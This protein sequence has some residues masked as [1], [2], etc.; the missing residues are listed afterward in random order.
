MIAAACTRV[1]GASAMTRRILLALF[2]AVVAVSCSSSS[3]LDDDQTPRSR[4]SGTQ[5]ELA[6]GPIPEAV[7]RDASGRELRMSIE[8]P[9]RA[10]SYPLIIFSPGYAAT[11][12]SY[13][14]LTSH[15]ASQGYVV[16]KPFHETAR[17]QEA[18][19]DFWQ[20]QTA[21][22]WRNRVRDITMILDSLDRLQQDYPELQGKIDR[23]KIGVG[24]HSYGAFTAMLAGGVRTYP[25]AVSYADPR[26]TAVMAISPQG[27]GAVRGLTEQSF[28]ELRKPTLFLT[29]TRDMG[30]TEEE[31]PEWRRRAYELSPEGDKWFVVIPNAGQTAFT[32]LRSATGERPALVGPVI[33]DPIEDPRRNPMINPQ[34]R[35]PRESVAGLRERGLGSDIRAITLAFWDTYLRGSAEART[36]LE[37][38]AGRGAE[39]VRK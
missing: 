34:D 36:T 1:A 15:W 32:G 30:A 25:G 11:P 8:Y 7:L 33:G 31:T 6:V 24:G 16:V 22:D 3:G 28:A 38:A 12:L 13:V 2:L 5:G 39:V 35:T 37:G 20:Q 17:T 18:T 21:T 29:G 4:Y 27:P 23:T 19:T 14:G 10:G 9:I 26:I